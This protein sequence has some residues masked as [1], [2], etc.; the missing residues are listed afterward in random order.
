MV[1][2][3]W[4]HYHCHSVK[5]GF[6][7]SLFSPPCSKVRN[8]RA[9]LSVVPECCW[10]YPA[11]HWHWVSIIV[12][13]W[14]FPRSHSS[15]ISVVLWSGKPRSLP[16]IYRVHWFHVLRDWIEHLCFNKNNCHG[17]RNKKWPIPQ[18]AKSPGRMAL[19][20]AWHGLFVL[21]QSANLLKL[22]CCL[23]FSS[24][25]PCGVAVKCYGNPGYI[26]LI[27]YSQLLPSWSGQMDSSRMH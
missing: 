10:V 14:V 13:T 5:Q 19:P 17:L 3:S 8:Q 22:C 4:T 1:V 21:Y 20:E 6:P 15:L 11:A 26:L 24:F 16:Q 2:W 12:W 25:F 23:W 18:G 9:Q 27:K 7:A